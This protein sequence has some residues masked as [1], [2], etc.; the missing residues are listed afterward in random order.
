MPEV[1][2][3]E[4]TRR[5]T[6]RDIMTPRSRFRTCTPDST[7]EETLATMRKD[8]YD[9]MP[10]TEGAEIVGYVLRDDLKKAHGESVKPFTRPVSLENLRSCNTTI[11][12]VLSRIVQDRFFFVL[13][14][15]EIVGLVTYADFDKRPVRV[16]LYLLFSN[17]ESSL[18]R[19]MKEYDADVS[20]WLQH[21]NANQRREVKGW[22]KRRKEEGMELDELDCFSLSHAFTAV[23]KEPKLLDE[24]GDQ[25]RLGDFEGL[26]D[27]RNKV[28]HSGLDVAAR[29]DQLDQLIGSKRRLLE[30]QDELDNA[31]RGLTQQHLESQQPK[32]TEIS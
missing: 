1:F 27:L 23:I 11:V 4:L 16:L 9:Q 26:V 14:G 8:D 5:A 2:Y 6:V 29:L 32:K 19:L 3:R 15:S 20:H 28:S 12:T 25:H 18:L 10:V 30:I 7:V 31:L 21:L 13:Y 24:I 22:H 17:M